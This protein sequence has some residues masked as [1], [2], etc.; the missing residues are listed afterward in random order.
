MAVHLL[1]VATF[2]TLRAAGA[3]AL[4][5]AA[6]PTARASEPLD[7]L[8]AWQRNSSY[9]DLNRVALDAIAPSRRVILVVGATGAGKSSTA[10]TLAG[11]LHKP[12][13]ASASIAS[14][15]RATAHRDYNFLAESW[16]VI[17]TPGLGDTNRP[18]ADIVAELRA[19]AALAPHGVSAVVIALPHGR[20]SSTQD[21]ALREI[22]ALFGGAK[23]VRGTG[24]AAAPT[25]QRFDDFAIVAFTSAVAAVAEG[26]QLLTRDALLDEVAA[27]PLGAFLRTFVNATRQ[28]VVA[29][30]NAVEPHRTSSRRALHQRVIDIEDATGGRRLDVAVL[31]AADGGGSGVG[32]VLAVPCAAACTREVV[33]RGGKRFE[34]L[35]CELDNA[36]GG[37]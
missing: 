28:R 11:R 6:A 1:R 17:D 20:F 37:V 35:T 36:H 24:D 18:H 26:R 5:W 13:I 14:A 8:R 30:E 25:A 34:V 2:T 3:L 7:D 27:L 19:V 22:A 31:S 33:W 21:A 12:F 10:N 9:G 4:A 23:G 32:G 16:R 15:T 29:V